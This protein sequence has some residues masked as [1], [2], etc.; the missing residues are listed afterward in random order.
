MNHIYS[1]ARLFFSSSIFNWV[2]SI[3]SL[4]DFWRVTIDAYYRQ[5]G[6][7]DPR[8]RHALTANLRNTDIIETALVWI[9]SKQ[10]RFEILGWVSDM[11]P[12][13]NLEKIRIRIRTWRKDLILIR[14]TI[15]LSIN[16]Q[17]M[18]WKIIKIDFEAGVWTKTALGSGTGTVAKKSICRFFSFLN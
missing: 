13:P 9:V 10:C 17:F 6:S 7:P 11:E 2:M 4:H 1:Y 14:P 15:F 5:S 3:P 8:T 12:D 16:I 18:Y